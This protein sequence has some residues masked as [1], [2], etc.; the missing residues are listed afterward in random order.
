[1][2]TLHVWWPWPL[3]PL[4]I[5]ELPP[6]LP[7]QTAHPPSCSSAAL[8]TNVSRGIRNLPSHQVLTLRSALTCSSQDGRSA[9][10]PDLS[11]EQP[12]SQCDQAEVT[13]FVQCIFFLSVF[14]VPGQRLLTPFIQIECHS[15]MFLLTNSSPVSI[16][17]LSMM[18][19][20]VCLFILVLLAILSN[21]SPVLAV[22]WWTALVSPEKAL[23]S[24]GPPRCHIRRPQDSNFPHMKVR[25]A[26]VI[27]FQVK[28]KALS[29]SCTCLPVCLLSTFPATL[30]VTLNQSPI[31]HRGEKSSHLALTQRSAPPKH[32]TD[33]P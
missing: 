14:P 5:P 21:M 11:T 24:D 30:F 12:I 3:P 19:P 10:T 7:L 2:V 28:M 33:N 29:Y 17:R 1:M 31:S 18:P 20:S 22:L 27:F 32:I 9:L 6:C 25:N 13:I 4:W 8:H 23:S 26:T 16:Q 15:R